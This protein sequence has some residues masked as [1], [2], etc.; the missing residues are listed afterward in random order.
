MLVSVTQASKELGVSIEHIRRMI[1]SG[2]W[3]VYRLGAKCTRIDVQEIRALGK[4]IYEGERER[5]VAIGKV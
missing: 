3:P 2:R 1:R 5:R 4:L